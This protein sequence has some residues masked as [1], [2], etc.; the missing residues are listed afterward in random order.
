M[1]RE[2]LEDRYDVARI[3]STHAAINDAEIFS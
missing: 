3:F 1:L 2:D